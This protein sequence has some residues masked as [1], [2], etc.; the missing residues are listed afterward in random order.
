MQSRLN[1]QI[2]D[3]INT[4][5]ETRV[6][7]GIRNSVGRHNSTKNANLDLRSDGLHPENASKSTQDAQN[8]FPR[9]VLTKSSQ[10]N[11]CIQWILNKVMTNLITTW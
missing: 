10:T 1:S 8:E 7:P 6:L 9:L 4:A 5:I 3:I 2:L 11:H